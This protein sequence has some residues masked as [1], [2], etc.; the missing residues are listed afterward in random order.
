MALSRSL[1]RMYYL[2]LWD[3]LEGPKSRENNL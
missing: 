3:K 1:L 2:L